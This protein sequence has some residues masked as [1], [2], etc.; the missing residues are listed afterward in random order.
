MGA[1]LVIIHKFERRWSGQTPLTEL[2]LIGTTQP[3]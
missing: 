1:C 2:S 3:N